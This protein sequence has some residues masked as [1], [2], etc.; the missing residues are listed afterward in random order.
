MT[1][2]E[3]RVPKV[4]EAILLTGQSHCRSLIRPAWRAGLGVLL[5]LSTFFNTLVTRPQSVLAQTPSRV[6]RGVQ[7]LYEF[8]DG[9]STAI[10]DTSGVG[11]ALDLTLENGNYAWGSDDNGAYLDLTGPNRASNDTDSNKIYNACVGSTEISLEAWVLPANN[12]QGGAARIVT[13][14]LDPYHRNFQLMQNGAR[15]D[16]RLRTSDDGTNVLNSPDVIGTSPNLQHVVYTYDGSTDDARFY[17]DGSQA[18]SSGATS[19]SGSFSTWDA[20]YDFGI[21]NEFSTGSD[22]TDRD[23]QGRLYLVAVYCVAL[24]DVEVQQNYDAGPDGPAPNKIQGTVYDDENYNGD[25]D[26]EPG[27]AGVTVTAYNARGQEMDSETTGGDGSYE[28]DVLD[29]TSVRL[30]FSN[31]PS[32]Y[33]PSEMVLTTTAPDSTVDAGFF[34]G[35]GVCGGAG[36]TYQLDWGAIG[37]QDP[38]DD[39]SYPWVQT[40]TD[41]AGSGVDMTVTIPR[42]HRDGNK[43]YIEDMT[44]DEIDVYT[45]DPQVLRFWHPDDST[46]SNG[47]QIDQIVVS[48]S[49]PVLVDDLVFGGNRLNGGT[50]GALEVKVYDGPDL[51]GNVVLPASTVHADPGSVATVDRGT[52]VPQPADAALTI[53]DDNGTTQLDADYVAARASY[54]TVGLTGEWH[55]AIVD[56]NDMAIQSVSWEQYGSSSSDAATAR[57]NL[58]PGPSNSSYLGGFLFKTIGTCDYGDLPDAGDSGTYA[59]QEADDGARHRTNTNGSAFLGTA[60]DDEDEGQPT[61]AANGDDDNGGHDED[62]VTFLGSLIPGENALIRVTAGTAGYLSAFIDFDGDSSLDEVTLVSATSGGAGTPPSPGTIGDML[63]DAPDVY[64]MT[65]EVPSSATDDDIYSRFRFTAEPNHGGNS[66]TGGAISGEVE[67]YVRRKASAT[68]VRITRLAAE[69]VRGSARPLKAISGVLL[70]GLVV[71][72]RAGRRWRSTQRRGHP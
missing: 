16:A 69:G 22:T 50:Y 29:G 17:I 12:T 1:V 8:E 62:G 57:D 2:K 23:W 39:E 20:D 5:V 58:Q 25:N 61:T 72:T 36:P 45:N 41:V 47:E 46:N 15:Y 13:L 19:P 35:S 51:T 9:S 43:N 28:L 44:A 30:V 67:D 63:L 52:P 54:V 32:G 48:F 56:Y 6:T 14:S 4:K 40:F 27:L 71:L 55:W 60:P 64:T 34:L 68:A 18:S 65:I 59:T 66:A 53:T 7:A 70:L 31:A 49:E 10:Q 11:A 37:W 42:Q 21:G 24:S 26:G 33:Q 3:S 38:P